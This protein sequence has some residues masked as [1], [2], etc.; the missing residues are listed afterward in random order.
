M[1]SLLDQL[2]LHVILLIGVIVLWRENRRLVAKL[3][4]LKTGQVVHAEML[5]AQNVQ[6]AE[7]KEQTNGL[8]TKVY[9]PPGKRP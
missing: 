3:E 9:L 6:I 4:D 8:T 2:P 1:I 5:A 7:I